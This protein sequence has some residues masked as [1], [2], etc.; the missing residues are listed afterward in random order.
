MTDPFVPK[1]LGW[2]LCLEL[3]LPLPAL[4]VRRR[5]RSFAGIRRRCH[6]VRHS[7]SA[8]PGRRISARQL[9]CPGLGTAVPVSQTNGRDLGSSPGTPVTTFRH[10]SPLSSLGRPR[11]GP[12]SSAPSGSDQL[13]SLPVQGTGGA[14]W[15]S[16]ARVRDASSSTARLTAGAC[17][18]GPRTTRLSVIDHVRT[19][20]S[21]RT[22][23]ARPWS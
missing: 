4:M 15:Q 12:K 16:A 3:V 7:P 5:P 23:L 9:S 20:C 8:A 21:T 11:D 6:A 18:A 10:W 13:A 1:Q 19:R 22:A 17:V 14:P 2:G